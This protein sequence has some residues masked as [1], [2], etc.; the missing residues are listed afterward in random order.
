MYLV[1]L[2]LTDHGFDVYPFPPGAA[3]ATSF[4]DPLEGTEMRALKLHQSLAGA[5]F[6]IQD[7]ASCGPAYRIVAEQDEFVAE[8]RAAP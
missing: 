4:H 3:G 5:E 8:D 2:H 1:H 6:C 7:R